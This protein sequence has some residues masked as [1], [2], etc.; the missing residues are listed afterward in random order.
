MQPGF[1]E[2]RKITRLY[3]RPIFHC[4]QKKIQRKLE[5]KRERNRISVHSD[6]TLKLSM[7]LFFCCVVVRFDC[8]KEHHLFHITIAICRMKNS[9]FFHIVF[10]FAVLFLCRRQTVGVCLNLNIQWMI[11]FFVFDV[12]PCRCVVLYCFLCTTNIYVTFAFETTNESIVLW[13]K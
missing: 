11:S 6:K 7:F 2:H 3:A 10:S 13:I 12:L 8:T 5:P 4:F 9:V 1:D